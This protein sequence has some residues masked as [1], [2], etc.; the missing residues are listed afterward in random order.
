M[1]PTS[2]P[3]QDLGTSTET[4]KMTQVLDELFGV[5]TATIL[6]T[7]VPGATTNIIPQSVPGTM[8]PLFDPSSR[9]DTDTDLSQQSPY[10]M[11]DGFL[12][13]YTPSQETHPSANGQFLPWQSGGPCDIANI[14][15]PFQH[16]YTDP[17][18]TDSRISQDYL[19]KMGSLAF[20]SITKQP[21]PRFAILPSPTQLYASWSQM[22]CAGILVCAQTLQRG[23]NTELTAPYLMVV[24]FPTVFRGGRTRSTI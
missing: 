24:T 17:L 9:G 1:S 23:S 18:G 4:D 22:E 8:D 11:A 15:Q 20:I 21:S 2:A 6:P 10:R 7:V 14:P 19:L 3:V 13:N 12:H 16:T 5:G